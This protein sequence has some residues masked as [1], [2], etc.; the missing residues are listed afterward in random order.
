VDSSWQP[1]EKVQIKEPLGFCTGE[2]PARVASG[3][4][5]FFSGVGKSFL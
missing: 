1:V 4:G 3:N 5:G 2:I